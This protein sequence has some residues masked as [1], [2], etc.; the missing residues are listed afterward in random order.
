MLRY[1][2]RIK[3]RLLQAMYRPR[4]KRILPTDAL[5]ALDEIDKRIDEKITPLLSELFDFG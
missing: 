1:R 5:R 3:N 4:A 2:I